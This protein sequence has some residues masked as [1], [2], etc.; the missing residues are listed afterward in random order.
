MLP[1]CHILDNSDLLFGQNSEQN[2]FAKKWQIAAICTST[3]ETKLLS[4]TYAS[5]P[6]PP[7]CMQT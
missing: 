2:I 3:L 6:P 4:V 1:T 7:G 5:P